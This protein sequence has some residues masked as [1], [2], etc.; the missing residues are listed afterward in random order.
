MYL[1]VTIAPAVEKALLG[2]TVTIK[3]ASPLG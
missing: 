1:N 3:N 2:W